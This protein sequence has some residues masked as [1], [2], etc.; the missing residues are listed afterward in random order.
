[1]T[2]IRPRSKKRAAQERKYIKLRDW[3][4]EENPIC[5]VKGCHSHSVDVHHKKGRIGELL[6]DFRYFL[7]V[8]RPHHNYIEHH[9]EESKAHGYS[10]SR[11]AKL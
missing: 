2:S 1:M 7:A 11:L 6:T 10:L 9:P 4:L 8:C 5:E 3:Y